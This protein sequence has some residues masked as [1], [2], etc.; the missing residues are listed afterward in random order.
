MMPLILLG[1]GVLVFLW[2]LSRAFRRP[3]RPPYQYP[4][5]GM[6]GPSQPV[7]SPVGP[8]PNY[9]PGPR[10]GA[11]PMGNPGYAPAGP[12]VG[13]PGYGPP[14][15]YGYGGPPPP[16]QRTGGGFVSGALGGLGGAIAGNIL[17]D[18]FGRPH[19]TEGAPPA[20]GVHNAGGMYPPVHP[21]D[22]APPS[23]TYDPTAGAGGDW[24]GTPEP[25]PSADD[26]SGS[27][28]AGAGGDWGG[29]PTQEASSD[30]GAGGDWGSGD[31]GGAGGDGERWLQ[32]PRV[33]R[34]RYRW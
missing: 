18:Q 29:S 33:D 22:Q 20:G 26:W 1:V 13:N 24:G 3:Q 27:G 25:A 32:R 7:P 34:R 21:G 5:P 8:A 12:A 15:G 23:E 30:P 10:P 4:A 11:P 28:D 31:D 14:P 2:L 17:Y 6:G 19:P 9:G 16:P